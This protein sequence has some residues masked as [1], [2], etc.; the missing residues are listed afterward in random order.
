MT[1]AGG[2]VGFLGGAFDPV[3]IGHL[4]GAMAVRDCLDLERVDL[5][6]PHN[7]P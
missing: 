2:P 5:I 1:D 3:H 7:L 6:P 4:R